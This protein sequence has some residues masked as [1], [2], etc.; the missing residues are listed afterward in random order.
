MIINESS[1][2]RFLWGK[3]GTL[4]TLTTLTP[5]TSLKKAF[6]NYKYLGNYL[7]EDSRLLK[8]KLQTVIS[9]ETVCLQSHVD[10]LQWSIEVTQQTLHTINK[11]PQRSARNGSSALRWSG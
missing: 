3:N 1:P 9:C 8:C 11:N 2:F 7:L 10:S 6:Q 4:C 5:H